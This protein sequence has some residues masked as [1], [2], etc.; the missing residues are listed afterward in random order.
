VYERLGDSAKPPP[1]TV[2]GA[3]DAWT[4][5][6]DVSE[7]AG[8]RVDAEVRVLIEHDSSSVAWLQ[9][10]DDRELPVYRS[11]GGLEANP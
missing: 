1:A 5:E 7:L 8:Q 11:R 10:R 6:F 2:F 9:P 4:P 3:V